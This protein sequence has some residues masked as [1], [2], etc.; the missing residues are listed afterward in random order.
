MFHWSIRHVLKV[1]DI[2]K[3]CFHVLSLVLSELKNCIFLKR[4]ALRD[5]G[6]YRLLLLGQVQPLMMY[7]SSETLDIF[8]FHGEKTNAVQKMWTTLRVI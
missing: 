2:C 8:C 4:V 3:A 7:K 6:T 5:L 1:L